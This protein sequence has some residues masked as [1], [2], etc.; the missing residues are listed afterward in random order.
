M[1]FSS[2]NCTLPSEIVRLVASNLD[3]ADANEFRLTCKSAYE[4]FMSVRTFDADHN[5]SPAKVVLDTLVHGIVVTGASLSDAIREFPKVKNIVLYKVKVSGEEVAMF[6]GDNLSL[7]KCVVTG[8]IEFHGRKLN[9]DCCEGECQNVLMTRD[10]ATF[11]MYDSVL[12]ERITVVGELEKL[13]LC[14]CHGHKVY[15]TFDGTVKTAEFWRV[16]QVNTDLV[17]PWKEDFIPDSLIAN[18]LTGYIAH[19]DD[20]AVSTSSGSVEDILSDDDEVITGSENRVVLRCAPGGVDENDY[21]PGF[22][23]YVAE[24]YEL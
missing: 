11:M 21:V 8:D 6:Q 1:E 10:Q 5:V 20:D 2:A 19:C 9:I 3:A 15:L 17:A 4:S 7:V 14:S 24:D 12:S 18:R 13:V 23:S 16:V 22:W